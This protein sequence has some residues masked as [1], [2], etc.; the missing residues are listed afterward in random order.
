[1]SSSNNDTVFL[2]DDHNDAG[3]TPRT[4]AIESIDN[5]LEHLNLV[6]ENLAERVY[7]LE[8]HRGTRFGGL[9]TLQQV[10]DDCN[11]DDDGLDD[12][13]ALPTSASSII[14][15]HDSTNSPTIPR[16]TLSS[17]MNTTMNRHG[18]DEAM[19]VVTPYENSSPKNSP[20]K[21]QPAVDASTSRDE[22]I[23]SLE[24]QVA[25][26]MTENEFIT[27]TNKSLAES[28]KQLQLDNAKLFSYVDY[29]ISIYPQLETANIADDA[30]TNTR[31]LSWSTPCN[32]TGQ[33]PSPIPRTNRS[34]SPFPVTMFNG[35][36][37]YLKSLESPRGSPRSNNSSATSS[38]RSPRHTTTP[39]P[40][41]PHVIVNRVD[42]S[43]RV[44]PL[45]HSI[46][47]QTSSTGSPR[48][49]RIKGTGLS[50]STGDIQ[51][52]N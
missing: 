42:V 49:S 35:F 3:L 39:I 40:T 20:P 12:N 10:I 43:G 6:I 29:F 17:V 22:R 28:M 38:P 44:S 26:L 16:L 48:L 32:V 30:N 21:Q 1:M 37:D 46:H 15:R 33:Q 50:H 19:V 8:L 14:G 5:T 4:A 45:L 18:S 27:S 52:S 34:P 7:H 31:G 41:S 25:R 47:K 13:D 9:D 2:T 11:D 51:P 36:E 23:A 24:L